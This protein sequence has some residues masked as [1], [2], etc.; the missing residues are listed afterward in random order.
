M[1][2]ICCKTREKNCYYAFPSL[3]LF[4]IKEKGGVL[5]INLLSIKFLYFVRCSSYCLKFVLSYFSL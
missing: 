2:Q 5:C 3:Y 4:C 1:S